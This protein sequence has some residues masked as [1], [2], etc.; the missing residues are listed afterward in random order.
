MR[1]IVAI[2]CLGGSIGPAF[3]D[4]RM[5]QAE[6]ARGDLRVAGSVGKG[7]VTVNLDKKFNTTSDKD[8]IFVFR[9]PYLPP[10]CIVSVDAEQDHR[11]AIVANCG[12][13]GAP[14]A[15]GDPGEAGPAGP[16]G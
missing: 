10:T 7:G 13:T 3:A 4:I 14:G 12:P 8:G 9:V 2:V 16:V 6:I 1:V 15:K 11:Q 5:L